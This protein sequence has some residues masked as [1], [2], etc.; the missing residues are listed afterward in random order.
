MIWIWRWIREMLKR[1]PKQ[2]TSVKTRSADRLV[3]SEEITIFEVGELHRELCERLA[4]GRPIVL[5]ADAVRTV[6][7]SAAQVLLTARKA[8][9]DRGLSF[10]VS[11]CPKTI[12]ESLSRLGCP[13]TLVG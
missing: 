5:A 13:A 1:K 9:T 10:S 4:Q 6:D 8:W 3:L 11:R 12:R 7:T 2:S